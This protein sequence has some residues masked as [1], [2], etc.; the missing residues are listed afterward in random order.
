MTDEGKDMLARMVQAGLPIPAPV[1]P[2]L[3]ELLELGY[4]T[5]DPLPEDAPPYPDDYKVWTLTEAGRI[6][7]ANA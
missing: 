4:V 3:A 5:R 1:N 6:Q 2:G 7:E